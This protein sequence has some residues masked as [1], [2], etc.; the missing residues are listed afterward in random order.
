MGARSSWAISTSSKRNIGPRRTSQS[1]AKGPSSSPGRNSPPPLI[2]RSAWSRLSSPG[3]EAGSQTSSLVIPWPSTTR[4]QKPGPGLASPGMSPLCVEAMRTRPGPASPASADANPS[5]SLRSP[6]G[7]PRRPLP[8]APMDKRRMVTDTTAPMS[9]RGSVV[10]TSRPAATRR[11][12][13]KDAR[14]SAASSTPG[15]PYGRP[16]VSRPTSPSR[17]PSAP[18]LLV[19]ESMNTMGTKA[20][21]RNT[22]HNSTTDRPSLRPESRIQ[23]GSPSRNGTATNAPSRAIRARP[24]LELFPPKTFHTITERSGTTASNGEK[25]A[26]GIPRSAAQPI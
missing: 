6:P 7:K 9:R 12:A 20:I 13:P 21:A 4:Y 10:T 22:G 8:K 14:T 26:S 15:P 2:S 19:A 18:S 16:A 23:A 3:S 11:A 5:R 25:A 1:T 24:K 17:A